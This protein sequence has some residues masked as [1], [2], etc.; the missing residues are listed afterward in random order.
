MSI[1][2]T[3]P[4]KPK[5]TKKIVELSKLIPVKVNEKTTVWLKPDTD[6]KAY[7]ETLNHRNEIMSNRG[8]NYFGTQPQH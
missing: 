4:T 8:L 1:Q 7:L 3:K 6:I 5:F 2:K